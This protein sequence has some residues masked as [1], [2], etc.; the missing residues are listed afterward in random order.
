MAQD[1]FVPLDAYGMRDALGAAPRRS[2]SN[3]PEEWRPCAAATRS[4]FTSNAQARHGCRR[5]RPQADRLA[6]AA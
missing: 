5:A 4:H 3:K 2:C 6:A 1:E